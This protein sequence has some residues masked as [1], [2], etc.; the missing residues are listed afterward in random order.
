[1]RRTPIQLR[2][3]VDE[4]ER[5]VKLTAPERAKVYAA[6]NIGLG[7]RRMVE[8]RVRARIASEFRRPSR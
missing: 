3:E 6:A 7:E 2:L 5:L 4:I 8:A 1:M